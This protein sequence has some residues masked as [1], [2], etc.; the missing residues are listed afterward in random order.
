MAIYADHAF[1][2]SGFFGEALT[3]ENANKWLSLASDEIDTLT[4]GRLTF[5]FPTVEAHIEKVKKAVCAIAEALF[6]IDLQRKAASAQVTDEGTYRGSVASIS[7]GRESISYSVNNASASVYA[8][9]AANAAEQSRL[10]GSIAAKYLANIPDANG[11][12]L[13]YA[14]EVR[15][16]PKHNNSV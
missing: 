5:A 12:N 13:L 2:K 1:Y 11:I 14:G 10:I 8:A 9:A 16:V 4:F 3:E 15:Y 7:S 6:Y